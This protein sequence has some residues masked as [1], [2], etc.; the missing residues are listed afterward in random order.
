[1]EVG[2]SRLL[3][4]FRSGRSIQEMAELPVIKIQN[5]YEDPPNVE[6]KVPGAQEIRETDANTIT[7]QEE[8]EIEI[9]GAQFTLSPVITVT[10]KETTLTKDGV[11]SS[12][13][14][15]TEDIAIQHSENG[16]FNISSQHNRELDSRSLRTKLRREEIERGNMERELTEDKKSRIPIGRLRQAV[17]QVKKERREKKER[18][19][20]QNLPRRSSLPKLK[21]SRIPTKR[22]TSLK[23]DPKT[24][25]EFD[26]IYEEIVDN[27]VKDIDEKILE[28]KIED[29][30]V[31]ESKFEE[32]IHAYDEDVNEKPTITKISKIPALRRRGDDGTS[33]IGALVDR[34]KAKNATAD[35]ELKDG[36]FRV[37]ASNITI[38]RFSRGS[39][40]DMSRESEVTVVKEIDSEVIDKASKTAP[41]KPARKGRKNSEKDIMKVDAEDKAKN[42][43]ESQV[44]V[45]ERVNTSVPVKPERAKRAISREVKKDDKGTVVIEK[46]EDDN[47]KTE[48]ITTKNEGDGTT[49]KTTTIERE[50]HS[51]IPIRTERLIRTYSHGINKEKPVTE[52]FSRHFSS[53]TEEHK[54]N[55][56]N[57]DEKTASAINKTETTVKEHVTGIPVKT[58]RFTRG[59]SIEMGNIRARDDSD[60]LKDF[61]E[62]GSH[63]IVRMISKGSSSVIK[64]TN[65]EVIT[66]EERKE[67]IGNTVKETFVKET[68][69]EETSLKTDD[70][71]SKEIKDENELKKE[72]LTTEYLVKEGIKVGIPVF[73]KTENNTESVTENIE[74]SINEVKTFTR[75][76]SENITKT[77]LKDS[78]WQRAPSFTKDTNVNNTETVT[79]KYTSSVSVQEGAK[80]FHKSDV[81]EN[82]SSS[83]SIKK[84][85]EYQTKEQ[86]MNVEMNTYMLRNPFDFS[87]KRDSYNFTNENKKKV[88]TKDLKKETIEAKLTDAVKEQKLKHSKDLNETNQSIITENVIEKTEIKESQETNKTEESTVTDIVIEKKEIEHSAVKTEDKDSDTEVTIL[89]GN[90]SR[91]KNKI[92]SLGNSKTMKQE[93]IDL[94]KST[95]VSSKIAVFERLESRESITKDEK[96]SALNTPEIEVNIPK[97]EDKPKIV[98]ELLKYETYDERDKIKIGFNY[99]E[100][101]YTSEA[102]IVDEFWKSADGPVNNISTHNPVITNRA[103]LSQTNDESAPNTPDVS[104]VNSITNI[105]VVVNILNENQTVTATR[106]SKENRESNN[107]FQAKTL[108]IIVNVETKSNVKTEATENIINVDTSTI[109]VSAEGKDNKTNIKVDY[110]ELP[111]ILPDRDYETE[112]G[113]TKPGKINLNNWKT[114]V[115]VNKTLVDKKGVIKNENLDEIAKALPDIGFKN[116]VQVSKELPETVDLNEKKPEVARTLPAIINFNINEARNVPTIVPNNLYH[117]TKEDKSVTPTEDVKVTSVEEKD[118]LTD[119]EV[120]EESISIVKDEIKQ[121]EIEIPEPIVIETEVIPAKEQE[122]PE[123]ASYKSQYMDTNNKN[124]KPVPGKINLNLWKNQVETNKTLLSKKSVINKELEFSK[125]VNKQVVINRPRKV[126]KTT[127]DNVADSSKPLPSKV[128]VTSTE[129][130]TVRAI[131]TQVDSTLDSKVQTARTLPGFINFKANE[132]QI[133]AVRTLP[134]FLDMTTDG[135]QNEEVIKEDGV[136]ITVGEA[137][138]FPAAKELQASN[139]QVEEVRI[140]PAYIDIKE[141][142]G[143]HDITT[144]S[145]VN[146][147]NVST[148]EL[149]FESNQSGELKTLPGKLDLRAWET[150]VEVNKTLLSTISKEDAKVEII[151]QV[152]TDSSDSGN[153]EYDLKVDDDFVPA[154]NEFAILKR[155]ISNVNLRIVDENAAVDNENDLNNNSVSIV[156]DE[157]KESLSDPELVMDEPEVRETKASIMN[158][159]RNKLY[160][161]N[162]RNILRNTESKRLAAEENKASFEK[163]EHTTQNSYSFDSNKEIHTENTDYKETNEFMEETY[164]KIVK[165]Y[166]S[167][168]IISESSTNIN[169]T[170][171]YSSVNNYSKSE[172]NVLKSNDFVLQSSLEEFGS[173][174]EL[175][176]AKSVAELDLGDAVN[177]NVQRILGRIKSV[178]FDSRRNVKTEKINVKEMPKKLSVLEKIRLFEGKTVSKTAETVEKVSAKEKMVISEEVYE[179][180]IESLK[181]AKEKYGSIDKMP[182]L[183]ISETQSMPIIAFGTALVDPR[184]LPHLVKAAIDLGYRAFDTA[185]IY[186]NEKEIGAAINEKIQDGTVKR[187]DLFIMSK[188]W[189]TFHRTDLVQGACRASLQ[190]LGLDYF[191]LYMIHNPMSFKEGPDPI[192]KIASVVQ[193][194]SHDYLDAWYGMQ[195]LVTLGLARS[196]GV[197]NF[198]ASQLQRIL[199]KGSVRPAVNQVECHPYLTQERLHTFCAEKNIA[200]SCFGVLG[201][202]GTPAEYKNS[203]TAA[204]DDPLVKVMAS[205]LNVTPAQLLI[206]Y[207]I[208]YGHNVVVKASSA[209]HLWDNL[210]ALKFSLDSAQMTALHALNKNKRTFTFQGMGDTHKN[211]PFQ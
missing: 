208:E 206:R 40:R 184:L 110:Y 172:F 185:Y 155:H 95:S 196:V 109:N 93:D 171:N 167:K 189:S 145:D 201:S 210:Q 142:V 55:N 169:K 103:V 134:A 170:E 86:K 22:H 211:Y 69:I 9:G 98:E 17:E 125:L 113:K 36:G 5:E 194:S 76:A 116:Q 21:E 156:N 149:N 16:G 117:K 96:L 26:K 186:G 126:S 182:V 14:T 177:G 202:K 207:Q 120:K 138:M 136:N 151:K 78:T 33:K 11:K 18:E 30:E 20:Q 87:L 27:T 195:Q 114:Q 35:S 83:V 67:Q 127:V 130:E 12:K 73:T 157:P 118:S 43:K 39:S 203:T 102:K 121:P 57:T 187:E 4:F 168:R 144:V 154:N 188:L 148:S 91:L 139:F 160:F 97:V 158:R 7:N 71:V 77:E 108:P 191:D 28:V 175:K 174:E 2:H 132:D 107:K 115:A 80:S 100:V 137:R 10:Q 65:S 140:L 52:K 204:I 163:T 164:Q 146:I 85:T 92:S 153:E 101:I 197:S 48:I 15:V 24:E 38:K 199:N 128:S 42:G 68:I 19:R 84:V 45:E 105:P 44:T 104:S 51:S 122:L 74:T 61:R 46:F 200:I 88:D 8:S 176:R 112:V 3:K 50:V 41:V 165:E 178:D 193:Y 180:K 131:P 190:N 32:I 94:P 63:N 1:M 161:I 56:E 198:N 159:I 58:E 162:Y 209:E 111:K 25:D 54:T 72:T 75:S 60:S 81:T 13:V 141:S 82:I 181:A 119:I 59:I 31:L 47:T 150:Q 106:E 62:N 90:V 49:I 66:T 179:E 124:A 53:K 34:V 129:L 205:G 166:T 192:P 99:D 147:V 123:K 89:K 79:N 23:L 64:D 6:S 29:T 143:T 70:S 133:E 152:D 183:A 135:N 37:T 173:K